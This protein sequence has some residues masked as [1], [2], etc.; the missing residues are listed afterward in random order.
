MKLVSD[1]RSKII[2]GLATELQLATF[3]SKCALL[4]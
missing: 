4:D 2:D 1:L 3:L